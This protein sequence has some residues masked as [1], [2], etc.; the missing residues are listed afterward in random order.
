MDLHEYQAKEV[1]GEFGIKAPKFFV[2]S[3]LEEAKA[4]VEKQGME[5]A[6]VKAQVHAGGRGKAGGVKLAKNSSQIL[7]YVKEMLGRR[8]VTKQTLGEGALVQKVMITTLADIE[9]EYYAS[10]IVD[11][12]LARVC[13][14]LSKEGGVEIE[15][16]AHK[17]PKAVRSF[18]ISLSGKLR[19]YQKIDIAKFMGWPIGSQGIPFLQ[20]LIDAFLAKDASMIEINPMVLTKDGEFIALDA[21]ISIDDNALYRQKDVAA[22]YDPAQLPP[23]EVEAKKHDLSYV[24]LTGD[25]GC[26]VNGA[27]LAMATMDIIQYFGRSPAN[28]LDVGGSATKEKVAEGFKIILQD[29]SVKAILINIFGGIMNCE[30]LA[31]GVVDAAKEIQ[32]KVP[33]VVRMEG[34]QVEA[35]KKVLKESGI[36]IVVVEDL[37]M[38]AEKVTAFSKGKD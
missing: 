17:D 11:R 7:E 25:I 5:K 19:E 2:A 33:L 24:A 1:L 23:Q 3:S 16:V 30:T 15:E 31:F 32:L 21:K 28:F 8:L 18:P 35:G 4:I 22:Y 27:G 29:P 6:V 20:G 13:L 9:K 36:N 38:A 10:I 26:M 12:K 37:K 14:I 34:T